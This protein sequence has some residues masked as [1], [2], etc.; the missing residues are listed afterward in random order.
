MANG[1]TAT[2]CATTGRVLVVDDDG[3]FAAATAE[4]LT[5]KGYAA[6]T[7]REPSEAMAEAASFQPEVALLDLRLNLDCGIDLIAR[8]HT[9]QSDLLCIVVT[10]YP[11]LDSAIAALQK[12]AYDYLRKPVD[13]SAL[14][15][16]LRRSF[17]HLRL[18]REKAELARQLRVAQKQEAIGRLAGAAA[19]DF[20]N[21]LTAI[22]GNIDLLLDDKR[23]AANLPAH[24]QEGLRAIERGA[25]R[26][27]ELTRQLLTYTEHRPLEADLLDVNVL[28]QDMGATLRAVCRER[29]ELSVT[30]SPDLPP[31]RVNSQALERVL[32]NLVMNA[33]DAIRDGGRVEITT[34]TAALADHEVQALGAGEAGPHVVVAVTDTGC[35]MDT[36]TAERVFEP[37]FTTKD[38]AAGQ[39]VGL[40]EVYG[41]VRQADGWVT[42][43]STPG[44]GSTFR[45]YLPAAGA[46]EENPPPASE[47]D[48]P[49]RKP[50]VLLCED[51]TAVRHLIARMLE[52]EGFE[53]LSAANG[54]DAMALAEQRCG[55][56][57]VLLTDIRMPGMDGRELARRL[58]ELRP[59]MRIA[60]TSGYAA[61][62]EAFRSAG[63]AKVI[64]LQKPYSPRAA[65][66]Q[67]RA[68]LTPTA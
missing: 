42:V 22:M 7:A 64:F 8:L 28:V 66:E 50:V 10:A 40:S 63:G 38:D 13:P 34:Q 67:L 65:A 4:L 47:D 57:D 61:D 30:L 27:A 12:G 68:L 48:A 45:V 46:R 1:L 18:E 14:L 19:H 55:P 35:G 6:R 56:I 26:A 60:L 43:T 54:A 33:C 3:D 36:E 25:Q 59:Q 58:S 24:V 31:V 29:V 51:E 41:L 52:M 11:E 39:G 53:V 20:N 21:V 62:G 23:G 5:A 16:A 15:A 49:D 2:N 32:N 44:A 17:D 9:R 37:F